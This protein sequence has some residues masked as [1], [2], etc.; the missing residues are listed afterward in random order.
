MVLAHKPY[1]SMRMDTSYLLSLWESW[2]PCALFFS[3]MSIKL[4]LFPSAVQLPLHSAAWQKYGTADC[5]WPEPAS[6]G[7]SC[8]GSTNL[9]K[10]ALLASLQQAWMHQ[11]ECFYREE[12]WQSL[13]YKQDSITEGWKPSGQQGFL[14]CASFLCKGSEALHREG[15]EAM[16]TGKE[17]S[18]QSV[19]DCVGLSGSQIA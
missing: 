15:Y 9:C 2:S 1:T 12:P 11:C 18:E 4:K 6:L 7:T 3:Q 19:W 14:V 8:W 5:L 10:T 17:A 16:V 13:T